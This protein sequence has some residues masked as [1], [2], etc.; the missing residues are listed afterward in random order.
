MSGRKKMMVLKWENLDKH[1][2]KQICLEDGIPFKHL[3]KG[4]SYTKTN[5]KHL[6]F[7]KL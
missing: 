1:E 3:K 7:V 6:K 2:G 4:E 5:Y